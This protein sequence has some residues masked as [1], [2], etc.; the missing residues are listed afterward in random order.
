MHCNRR[1]RAGNIA[2]SSCCCVLPT[3]HACDTWGKLNPAYPHLDSQLLY[4][5]RQGN[6]VIPIAPNLQRQAAARKQRSRATLALHKA[7]GA[8]PSVVSAKQ[9][10]SAD[11][12]H[13]RCDGCAGCG[14]KSK[15]QRLLTGC[16]SK[17]WPSPRCARC[18]GWPAAFRANRC[19]APSL[20]GAHVSR[21]E[22]RMPGWLARCPAH[23]GC[24]PC[25]YHRPLMPPAAPAVACRAAASIQRL[26]PLQLPG[27]H[28]LFPPREY[29]SLGRRVAAC[30]GMQAGPTKGGAAGNVVTCVADGRMQH[31][32][33]LPSGQV[34]D[35]AGI[36]G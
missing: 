23:T 8:S 1:L 32:T 9:G 34:S 19:A 20:H 12:A 16:A 29:T 28:P 35:G 21:T 14:L 3:V 26:P 10:S 13:S 33:L 30:V 22:L 31:R 36:C 27:D 7:G 24:W 4:R 11:A 15:A 25:L 2:L 6:G 18:G 5:P 17:R